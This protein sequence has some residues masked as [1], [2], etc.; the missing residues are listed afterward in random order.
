MIG[1]ASQGLTRAS[2]M[3]DNPG[4]GG[5]GVHRKPLPRGA[6][7][8][9]HVQEIV[10]ELSA[11]GSYLD[12]RAPEESIQFEKPK[13][14][15]RCCRYGRAPGASAA[16]TKFLLVALGGAVGSVLRFWLGSYVN[17]RYAPRFPYGTFIINITA[18]FLIGLVLTVL[19]NRSGWSPNW[20]YLI[21]AGF[22]GGYST[23]STFEWETFSV[24]QQGE[25]LIAAMNV[26]LSVFVGFVSVWLGF[27]AGKKIA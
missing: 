9:Y 17:A 13:F 6:D 15:R 16:M 8:S 26:F 11:W 20:R 5:V 23:F 14:F 21:S 18:S 3:R 22:L 24:F 7:D 27:L 10:L 4:F 25:F 19:A 2:L 1:K 12:F